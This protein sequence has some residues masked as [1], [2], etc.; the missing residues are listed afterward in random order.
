MKSDMLIDN[1]VDTTQDKKFNRRSGGRDCPEGQYEIES[2]KITV[3]GPGSETKRTGKALCKHSRIHALVKGSASILEQIKIMGDAYDRIKTVCKNLGIYSP[4]SSRLN[5]YGDFPCGD[6]EEE[7]RKRIWDA[8]VEQTDMKS[9]INAKKRR[10]LSDQ[11]EKDELPEI[12]LENIYGMINTF[13]SQVNDLFEETVWSVYETMNPRWKHYKTNSDCIGKRRIISGALDGY[14]HINY[15]KEPHINDID[16]VFHLL[17][18][19][20]TAK[21]RPGSTKLTDAFRYALCKKE[22]AFETEYFKCKWYGGAC[23]LHLEF[24][25]MDLVDKF[26]EIVSERMLKEKEGGS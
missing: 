2:E 4:F 11:I 13:A 7:T 15:H 25:R 6:L 17:D 10:E 12:T 8:V 3:E 22:H 1:W 19:K 24:K 26:N 20:G 23:T 21:T 9:F 16:S 14:G 5:L 18:G